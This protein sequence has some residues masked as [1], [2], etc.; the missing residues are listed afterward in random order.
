MKAEL[1]A[2]GFGD[3]KLL[4]EEETADCHAKNRRV[5]FI[6]EYAGS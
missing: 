5:E 4:C 6:L 2:E 3:T 1:D